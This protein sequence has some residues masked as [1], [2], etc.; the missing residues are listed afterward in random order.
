MKH[1]GYL[2]GPIISEIDMAPGYS[3]IAK[4]HD[5]ILIDSI[6]GG[7][8]GLQ[9][10]M[11]VEEFSCS[12]CKQNYETCPHR[13]GQNYAGTEC[14]V[15]MEKWHA[16]HIHLVYKSADSRNRITDMLLISE[17]DK[18]KQYA[19]Y[20]FPSDANSRRLHLNKA[21]SLNLI[22]KEVLNHFVKFFSKA[23]SKYCHISS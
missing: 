9:P 1:E 22:P 2:F 10:S 16:S 19:W 3:I 15:S 17:L 12:I 23:P 4:T 7:Q 18:K 6:K 11:K 5:G 21:Y 8:R 20:G 13:I 14:D